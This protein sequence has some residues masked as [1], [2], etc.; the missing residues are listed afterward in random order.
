MLPVPDRD[1][2]PRDAGTGRD[3][4]GMSPLMPAKRPFPGGMRGL[5][6]LPDT[7]RLPDKPYRDR[8]GY[9]TWGID[10]GGPGA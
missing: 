9:I 1:S 4:T 2:R 3:A 10:T 6:I 8:L 7:L 5:R